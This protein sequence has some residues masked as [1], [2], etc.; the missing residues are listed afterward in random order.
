MILILYFVLKQCQIEW[1]KKANN[2][3]MFIPYFFLILL[4]FLFRMANYSF[5]VWTSVILY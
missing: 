3:V 5:T 2:T 4:Q 1:A